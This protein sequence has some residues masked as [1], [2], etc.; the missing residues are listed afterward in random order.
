MLLFKTTMVLGTA[1][2]Q[3]SVLDDQSKLDLALVS[4]DALVAHRGDFLG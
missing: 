3:T 1:L 4:K 2:P